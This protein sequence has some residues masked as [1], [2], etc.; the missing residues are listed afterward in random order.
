MRALADGTVIRTGLRHERRSE[1][2]FLSEIG[3]PGCTW[4]IECRRRRRRM[5]KK[6]K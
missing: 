2:R 5:R 6:R 4:L 1:I 3:Q